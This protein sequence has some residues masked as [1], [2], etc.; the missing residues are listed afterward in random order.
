MP[1]PRASEHRIPAWVLVVGVVVTAIL[2]ITG[3]VL[4]L[5]GSRH[6]EPPPPTLQNNKPSTPPMLVPM[7]TG[8]RVPT[9][10][11]PDDPPTPMP[12]PTLTPTPMPAPRPRVVAL[13]NVKRLTETGVTLGPAPGVDAIVRRATPR[14]HACAQSAHARHELR[15]VASF[16]VT[17]RVAPTGRAEQVV[18]TD[19]NAAEFAGCL[20]GALFHLLFPRMLGGKFHATWAVQW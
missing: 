2:C 5:H 8:T 1:A 12:M 16:G 13:D 15:D 7:P 20:S 11:Q 18:L 14:V 4:A 6:D 3:A 10:E 17:F 9:E 19:G